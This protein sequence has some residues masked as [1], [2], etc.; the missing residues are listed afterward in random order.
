V[1][2]HLL[3]IETSVISY[4]TSRRSRDVIIAAHQEITVEWWDRRRTD[5][6]LV[7]SPLVLQEAARGDP[8]MAS[9]RLS[10]L[11]D[12]PSL[13]I[14]SDAQALGLAVV[15]EHLLPQKALPDALHIAI[16]A[17]HDIDYLLTWNCTHIAN[18]E[19]LPRVTLLIEARGFRMPF[20]C[21]PEELLG[22]NNAH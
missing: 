14:S 22:V 20:V 17:V 4:L 13:E 1:P 10:V 19:I 16:A 9:R 7:V 5:F 12:L 11:K 6:D 8:E 18:A 21:T 2:E 3:Y 15:E